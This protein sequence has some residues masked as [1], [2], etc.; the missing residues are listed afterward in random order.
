MREWDAEVR[1]DEQLARRL[2]ADQFPELEPGDLRLLGEG[3]D[4]MVWLVDGR[5]VF[6]FP[7]RAVVVSGLEN[8]IRYLP[9]L[10]S[11]LPLPIPVP[12]PRRP[13]LDRVRLAVLRRAVP[14]GQ[15]ARGRRAR[16]RGAD[17][18]RPSAGRVPASP[19]R[20]RAR[21]RPARPTRCGAR[22]CPSG[23]RIR[24][25]GW[26]SSSAEASGARPVRHARSSKPRPLS[27]RRS[28]RRSST[29]TCTSGISSSTT[30]GVRR[31]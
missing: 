2:I 31:R 21:R 15:G 30:Q 5:W 26:T 22:T 7:R 24:T 11:L 14:S 25:R 27:G 8:E 16:R 10:A 17:R 28:R 1:V 13:A 19:A 3:W 23:S 20:G 6:R 18:A 4:A 12:T 29:A 9:Q